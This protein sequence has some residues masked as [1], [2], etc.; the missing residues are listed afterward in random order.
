MLVGSET[1][2]VCS[3]A[4]VSTTGATGVSVTLELSASKFGASTVGSTGAT[5]S[6]V[7]CLHWLHW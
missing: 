2:G 4:G 1:G 5:F 6:A 7:D 3:T